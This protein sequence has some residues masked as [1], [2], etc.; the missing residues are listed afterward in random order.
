LGVHG[1]GCVDPIGFV[2]ELD[3]VVDVIGHQVGDFEVL[4]RFD[5]VADFFTT[6]RA[7]ASS[8]ICGLP[9]WPR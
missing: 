1:L 5:E 8:A 9:R 3:V 6:L 2:A 4:S 7:T